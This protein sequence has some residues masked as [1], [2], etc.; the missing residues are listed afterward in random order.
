MKILMTDILGLILNTLSGILNKEVKR[1]VKEE[2]VAT[3]IRKE[4]E[5]A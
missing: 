5:L 3:I 2:P 1:N 4:I